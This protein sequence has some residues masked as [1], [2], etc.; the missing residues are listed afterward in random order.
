MDKGKILFI[1]LSIIFTVTACETKNWGVYL[2]C[3]QQQTGTGRVD[4]TEPEGG[5][6]GT[7]IGY[8]VCSLNGQPALSHSVKSN[9]LL[10]RQGVIRSTIGP[11]EQGKRFGEEALAWQLLLLYY[12]LAKVLNNI[13]KLCEMCLN[14]QD[15]AEF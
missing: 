11:P 12:I 6:K 10:V 7:D 5:Y 14:I 1:I 8:L 2:L 13:S 9:K 4:I 3:E 15:F